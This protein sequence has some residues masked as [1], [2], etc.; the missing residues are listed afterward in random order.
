MEAALRADALAGLG[1]I[2]ARRGM[3]RTEKKNIFGKPIGLFE[4]NLAAKDQAGMDAH[5][6]KLEA[7]G[8]T[9]TASPRTRS[10]SLAVATSPFPNWSACNRCIRSWSTLEE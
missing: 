3:I 7:V 8:L 5:L 2:Q 4:V 6:A 9:R 1:P 10:M